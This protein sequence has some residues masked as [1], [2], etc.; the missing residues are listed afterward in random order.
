[1]AQTLKEK[2]LS[3]KIRN[4]KKDSLVTAEAF[5]KRLKEIVVRFDKDRTNLFK[6]MNLLERQLDE[7]NARM[8]NGFILR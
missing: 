2:L 4:L 7:V 5:D 6:N 1:M 8:H 3:S